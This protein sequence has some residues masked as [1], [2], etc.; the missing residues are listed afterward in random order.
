MRIVGPM[1]AFWWARTCSTF[2]RIADQ[3]PL[4]RRVRFG[5]GRPLGFLRRTRLIMPGAVSQASSSAER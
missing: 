3:R 1:R 2:E 5:I 4:A